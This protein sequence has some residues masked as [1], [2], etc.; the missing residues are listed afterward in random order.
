MGVSNQ[1]GICFKAHSRKWSPFLT[2][3]QWPGTW[4]HIGQ[5]PTAEP[6]TTVRLKE[7]SYKMTSKDNLLF[8]W[9]SH[10]QSSFLL[11]Q[12]GTHTE[13]QSHP[14]CTEWEALEHSALNGVSPSNSSCLRE[15]C[16]RWRSVRYRGDAG[17]HGNKTFYIQ[18]NGCTWVLG[19][20]GSM[21]RACMCL[22]QLTPRAKKRT[23]HMPHP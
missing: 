12:M 4:D 13:S 9:I 14:M 2:L 20:S 22:P 18:C 5:E 16:L 21:H 7:S 1:Y 8:S 10:H 3:L 17:H 11:Q 15:P 19:D 6:N 23:G